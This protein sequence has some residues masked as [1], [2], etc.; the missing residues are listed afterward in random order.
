MFKCALFFDQYINTWN[1]SNVTDMEKMFYC[2][3]NFNRDIEDWDIYFKVTK[4]KL[5]EQAKE[6]ESGK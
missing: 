4:E 1:V 5:Q 3:Y 2:T 6:L